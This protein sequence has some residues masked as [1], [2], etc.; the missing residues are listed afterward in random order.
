MEKRNTIYKL[1]NSMQLLGGSEDNSCLFD[2]TRKLYCTSP[3][4]DIFSFEKLLI[5]NK[6][7]FLSSYTAKNV[8]ILQ[9]NFF[10][11]SNNISNNFYTSPVNFG[12]EWDSRPQIQAKPLPHPPPPS[13][14]MCLFVFWVFFGQN[15]F[16]LYSVT[17]NHNLPC[18]TPVLRK[19]IS[20]LSILILIMP[21]STVNFTGIQQQLFLVLLAGHA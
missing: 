13:V 16:I 2:P 18:S 1:V 10:N 15:S 7:L 8:I 17:Y 19:D 12:I 4:S 3:I 9:K 21:L 20:S 6:L 5:M 14:V 11:S